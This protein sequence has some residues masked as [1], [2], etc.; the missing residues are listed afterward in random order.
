MRG[1][2]STFLGAVPVVAL[3]GLLGGCHLPERTPDD[4]R[5][6]VTRPAAFA[7]GTLVPLARGFDEGKLIARG[8]AP[9]QPEYPDLRG[10]ERPPVSVLSSDPAAVIRNR[11]LLT[12]GPEPEWV[13]SKAPLP[14]PTRP[15]VI[16]E[17]PATVKRPAPDMVG[18][19]K[20]E[21][22]PGTFPPLPPLPAPTIVVE[23]TPPVS[24]PHPIPVEKTPLVPLPQPIP[25]VPD[26]PAARA[27]MKDDSVILVGGVAVPVP[28][29][30]LPASPPAS[31]PL[32]PVSTP[33]PPIRLPDPV[34][35]PPA[36]P[37]RLP[38]TDL[39]AA[40]KS[41]PA[42]APHATLPAIPDPKAVAAPLAVPVRPGPI[43]VGGR[44]LTY[45]ALATLVDGGSCGAPA[46]G[47]PGT[48]E[49]CGGGCGPGQCRAGSGPN[50]CEPFPAKTAAGRFVKL[51]Y[52]CM[53]CPDPCYQPRWEPI[54]DAAFFVDAP[55]PV[56]QTRV[57]W[58][59]AHHL[60]F[61]DRG[62]YFCARADG[63]GRGPRANAPALTTPYLDYH[64]ISIQAEAAAGPA[65]IT[66]VTPYRSI[67]PTPY[68]ESAAGFGDMQITAKNI[69]YDCE[70]FIF[71]FQMRTYIP[72]GNVG[73]GLGV[74]HTSLEPGLIAGLRVSPDTYL[75]AQ[76]A[77]WIPL[78]GD[79]D[80]QGAHLR[81]NFSVNHVLWRP[82]KD[83]Q[84]IGTL[85]F[86]GI[87]WQD[88]AF[89][90]AVDGPL[91]KL[92]GQTVAGIGAGARLFFCDRID[93]GVGGMF[94]VTGKYWA[95]E[96]MRFEFRYRF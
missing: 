86:N 92:S 20:R 12:T 45:D 52:E 22:A 11:A 28:P 80:Y 95:R 31:R 34:P 19:P 69:L 74:G 10:V 21:P 4:S 51:V 93:V 49:S 66:I 38:L 77:E 81:Y 72:T 8:V 88:G 16:A 67:N 87:S 62:E 17:E 40:P 48:C 79:T 59:Y 54:A 76:V 60:P 13:K 71:S 65:S 43:E 83:V 58:D 32:L 78:G 33:E 44:P 96:Q 15:A 85:E 1:P 70:L 82:V 91:Q 29:G 5:P 75:V 23:K 27:Q 89:T 63:N 55:R 64:D 39:P 90:D 42:V 26:R 24:L 94:G 68:A 35:P 57:R 6:V 14:V 7:P 3:L 61:P 36:A 25:V 53:C 56:T 37:N 30:P 50:K 73:K 46:L 2:R 84:L 18:P 47:S 9:D 41:P